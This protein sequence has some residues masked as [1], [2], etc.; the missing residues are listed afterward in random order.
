MLP[1]RVPL[2]ARDPQAS[3]LSGSIASRAAS[4]PIP[5]P[6]LLPSVG[7]VCFLLAFH[8]DSATS[9]LHLCRAQ[10][11][12]GTPPPRSHQPDLLP[13]VGP[14]NFLDASHP[15]PTTR[16]LLLCRARSL[17]GTP[18]PRI[19]TSKLSFHPKTKSL[20]RVEGDLIRAG[21]QRPALKSCSE[22]LLW[23]SALDNHYYL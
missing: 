4:T 6:N 23:D 7:P 8:P 21:F 12:P 3:P 5:Q 1:P 10:S 11:L 18:P 13:S 22:I 9:K 15:D 14:V 16:K 20:P 2:P 19:A 17:P